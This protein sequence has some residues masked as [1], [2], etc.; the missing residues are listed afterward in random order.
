MVSPKWSAKAF[1]DV[2]RSHLTTHLNP[3]SNVQVVQQSSPIDEVRKLGE[4]LQMRLITQ[5]EFD[6]KK[7]QL[8]EL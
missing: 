6:A 8:L 5:A 3:S 4:L 2:V 1:A 7:S